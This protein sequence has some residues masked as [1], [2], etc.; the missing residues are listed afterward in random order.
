MVVGAFVMRVGSSFTKNLNGLGKQMPWTCTAF[1]IGGLSLI[2]V[3]GTAGFISKWL[4]I[5]ASLKA[6][7]WWLAM[8]I[9]MS[10]LLAVVYVW[11][12]V[13]VLYMQ[14]PDEGSSAKEVPMSMLLPMWIM[15]IAC[16]YFGLNTDL[17]LTSASVAANSLL[18]GGVQ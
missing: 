18:G 12:A 7:L 16:V 8:L 15:A 6:D 3:P 1:V 5:D 11:K 10:S 4:L 9:V 13:E 14:Q 2:G 17:T